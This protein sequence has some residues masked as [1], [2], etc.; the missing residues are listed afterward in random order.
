ML[1]DRP[2]HT[3]LPAADLERAKRFYSEQL[4]LTSESEAP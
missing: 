4:G 1:A 3:T 2:L